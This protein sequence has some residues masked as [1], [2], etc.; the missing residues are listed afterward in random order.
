MRQRRR[1]QGRSLE[2]GGE[3]PGFRQILWRQNLQRQ[4]LQRQNPEVGLGSNLRGEP[5]TRSA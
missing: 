2:V 3:S 1:R 4:N 5:A